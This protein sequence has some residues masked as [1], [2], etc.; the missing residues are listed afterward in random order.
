MPRLNSQSKEAGEA[1]QDTER[2]KLR[3]PRRPSSG[4]HQADQEARKESYCFEEVG[5][6]NLAKRVEIL[7]K[8][9]TKAKTSAQKAKLQKKLTITKPRE[10][11]LPNY[12]IW[13][14]RNIIRL[15]KH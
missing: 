15:Q 9:I 12:E 8:K 7:K 3:R 1:A 10:S 6:E 14:T 13:I 2:R 4:S 11:S 5:A